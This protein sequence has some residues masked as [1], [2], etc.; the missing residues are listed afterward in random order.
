MQV[1]SVYGLSTDDVTKWNECVSIPSVEII[2]SFINEK[3]CKYN[4]LT[5]QTASSN[6]NSQDKT[7][8]CDVCNRIFIGN[9]QWQIHVKSRKHKMKLTKT[10]LKIEE[11]KRVE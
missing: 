7:Y 6:P 4:G 1:P 9:F 11:N 5:P 8:K 3:P 10:K 2:E